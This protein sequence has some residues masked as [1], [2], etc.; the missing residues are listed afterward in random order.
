MIYPY[1]SWK[2]MTLNINDL[3]G[4][5]I[6]AISTSIG[7]RNDDRNSDVL[8]QKCI[9]NYYYNDCALL[10]SFLVSAVTI[11]ATESFF[12]FVPTITAF[13]ASTTN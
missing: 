6:Y 8:Y 12:A 2:W 3:F 13:Q 1:W 9:A 7:A 5:N 11:T 10:L 4:D